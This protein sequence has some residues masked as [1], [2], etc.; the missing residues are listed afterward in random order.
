MNWARATFVL[1]LLGGTLGVLLD[2]WHVHTG[3]TRYAE[4]WVFG[5]ATWTIPL[6]SSA[7]V[8]VGVVPVAV[9]RAMHVEISAG[10]PGKPGRHNCVG[11]AL[12][13]TPV[14]IARTTTPRIVVATALFVVAYLLTGVLRGATCAIVLALIALAIWQTTERPPAKIAFGHAALAGLGGALVEMTLV[15]FGAFFHTDARLFGVA[16]WLPLLYVCA[17]L[18]LTPL[19]RALLIAAPSSR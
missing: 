16:P 17:S 11:S 9:E 7:G 10:V 13:T 2:A 12:R 4:P 6:F 15:H 3:T 19:A 14:E 8:L 5:I 1:A 18:A